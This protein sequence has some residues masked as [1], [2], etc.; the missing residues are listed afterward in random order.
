MTRSILR[1]ERQGLRSRTARGLGWNLIGGLGAQPLTLLTTM[2][3]ARLLTPSDFGVV[4][5]TSVLIGLAQMLNEFG[6]TSAIVQ[7]PTL[8]NE[9]VD[10]VFWFNMGMGLALTAVAWL[11]AEPVARFYGQPAVAQILPIAS[12][13]FV[14]SSLAL[15]P[16]ALLRRRID[17][18]HPAL[19]VIIAAGV[20]LVV[21]VSLALAGS[22]YWALVIG[23]LAG[24]LASAFY[25]FVAARW[26]PRLHCRW[27]ELRAIL[28]FGGTLSAATIVN[29]GSWN[30]DYLLIGRSLG[31]APL[32]QYT[33]AFNLASLPTRKFSWTVSAVLL[34]AFSRVQ[35]E[36]DSFR[37]AY[38]Q[39]VSYV[40]LPAAIVLTAAAVLGEEAILSL[41][42]DQWSAAV[43]PF[44]VLCVAGVVTAV[45]TVMGLAFRGLNR[46]GR[47]LLWSIVFF[48]ASLLGVVAGLR[49]GA[50][51]VAVG[52]TAA[53]IASRVPAQLDANRLVGVRPS[54][55]AAALAP[56][57]AGTVA[58]ALV[59]LAGREV[60]LAFATPPVVRL[61]VAGG[62]SVATAWLVVRA[63]RLGRPARDIEGF[64][65]DVWRRLV[66]R[67][68]VAGVETT[69]EP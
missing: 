66:T 8:A 20:A 54:A 41:Y 11:L 34:P 2:I 62:L 46:P 15:V 58:A 23:N 7:R 30:I 65:A 50:V 44:R 14:I 63:S 36:P 35:D 27:P 28:R 49:A 38:V 31:S 37:R 53:M 42:G 69:P 61:V 55:F 64:A 22:G 21:S 33:L 47:E 26:H 45:T 6:L 52:M 1:A 51:G 10:S 67:R 5:M 57:L 19:A 24:A 68:G 13:V 29:Y 12:L 56:A 17:F 60:L 39:C 43:A 59:A 3:L 32:G 16:H 25:L 40:A 9:E 4:A 18:R 48:G